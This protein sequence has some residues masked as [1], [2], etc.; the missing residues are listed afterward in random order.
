MMID[1]NWPM[2]SWLKKF[3]GVFS[4][5][6]KYLADLDDLLARATSDYE[7]FGSTLSFDKLNLLYEFSSQI[8]PKKKIS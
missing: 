1:L 6:E 2:K 8:S 4:E 7:K 5:E 3:G